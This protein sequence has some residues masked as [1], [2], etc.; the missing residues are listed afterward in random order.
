MSVKKDLKEIYNSISEEFSASR[1][2]PWEELQ[3]FIPYIKDGFK[4]LD[5]GCGNARVLKLFKDN[6]K[7]IEYTGIDFSDKL[8]KEAQTDFPEAKFKV[9]DMTEVD[10]SKESFDVVLMVASFHHLE[11]KQERIEL[12]KKVNSWLKPKG[13]LFMTNWNLWQRKYF[14]YFFKNVFRKKAVNDFFIPWK[15]YSEDKKVLWRYYHSF[16][17][18]ELNS[19]LKKTNFSL[20]PK[21][22]YYTKWNINSF[23]SKK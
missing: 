13:Y 1:A 14:K 11:T 3:V 5:L 23:V 4:V 21:G 15:K 2:F 18:K 8:I 6:N 7:E 20:E 10:F 9:S 17:Q 19:L 12:L 22:V 16:S